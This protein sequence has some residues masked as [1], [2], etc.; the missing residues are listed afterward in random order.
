MA[1]LSLIVPCYNEADNLLSFCKHIFAVFED[2]SKIYSQSV[3]ELIFVNDG[4]SDNTL[5]ILR[6]LQN[7]Q[8]GSCDIQ[9]SALL[10]IPPPRS[11]QNKNY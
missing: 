5:Q 7:A 3:F 2:I 1:K 8:E 9:D 6:S 11:M 10:S 4:S